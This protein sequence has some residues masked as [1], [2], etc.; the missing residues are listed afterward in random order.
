MFAFVCL[1]KNTLPDTKAIESAFKKW[2]AQPDEADA[3]VEV[4]AKKGSVMFAVGKKS[5]VIGLMPKAIPGDDIPYASDNSFMWPTAWKELKDHKA[6]LIVVAIGD[7]K[8]RYERDLFLARVIAA[9]TE[10]FPTAGVY[11]GDAATVHSPD[12]FR[13]AVVTKIGKA[14]DVPALLWV[15]SSVKNTTTAR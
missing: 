10:A 11:W 8:E 1:K 15:G 4:D 6:H 9:C 7:Y 12:M 5:A 14:D 2:F 13:K 3:K